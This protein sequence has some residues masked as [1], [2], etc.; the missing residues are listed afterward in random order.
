[1]GLPEIYSFLIA[2]QLTLPAIFDNV[3]T[4]FLGLALIPLA[5]PLHSRVL[6]ERLYLY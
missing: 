3:S 2:Q 5:V 1:M 6:V 4:I